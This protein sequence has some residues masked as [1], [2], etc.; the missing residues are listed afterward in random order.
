[1]LDFTYLAALRNFAVDALIYWQGFLQM[2]L[3]YVTLESGCHQLN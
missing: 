1:M 3:I 2:E